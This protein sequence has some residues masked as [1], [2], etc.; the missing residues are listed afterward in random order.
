ME[1]EKKFSRIKE[2]VW[3]LEE[4]GKE[5][6]VKRYADVRD[7]IK[8][9]KIHE[10]LETVEYPFCASVTTKGNEHIVVQPWLTD[11]IPVDFTKQS[12]RRA[13]LTALDALHETESFVDWESLPFLQKYHLLDKWSWRLERFLNKRHTIVSFLGEDAFDSIERYS[14]QALERL[15]TSTAREAPHTLLHGDV[16]HHNLLKTSEGTVSLIDFDLACTG[17]PDVEIGLWL[18]RVLPKVNYNAALLFEEEPRLHVLGQQAIAMLQY[19]NEMLREWSYLTTLPEKRQQTLA[20][21][22]IPFTEH[23]LNRWPEL[24]RFSNNLIEHD[25]YSP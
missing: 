7:A 5:Y 25:R 24:C 10:L 9:R 19:P 17:H 13:S 4:E 8:I 16:V 14:E 3:R 21:L 6:S 12:D 1:V 20:K 15:L 22:L 11:A 18:H 2:N 23:A